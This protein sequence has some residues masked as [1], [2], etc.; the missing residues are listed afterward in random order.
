MRANLIIRFIAT[1]FT[2]VCVS[3]SADM[4]AAKVLTIKIDYGN[5]QPLKVLEYTKE[6]GATAL[7]ALRAVAEVTTNMVGQY[8]MV[9]AVDGIKGERGVMAWYYKLDGESPKKIAANYP[10]SSEQSMSWIY[11]K[12]VCSITVD[13]PLKPKN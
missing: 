3:V 6:E 5:N 1:L 12:D 8:K 9:V 4:Q 11:K 2:F 13:G 7:D 10:L